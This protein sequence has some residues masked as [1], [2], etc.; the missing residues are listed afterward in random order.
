MEDAA[1]EFEVEGKVEDEGEVESMME[2]M[3]ESKEAGVL[4][5][6]GEVEVE[7]EPEPEVEGE[8]GQRRMMFEVRERDAQ[9]DF[10]GPLGG[11]VG[12]VLGL[13]A[14]MEVG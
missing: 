10:G 7:P 9:K 14:R 8:P 5:D 2:S 1:A 13:S 4:G 3:A 11:Q 12:R 6:D